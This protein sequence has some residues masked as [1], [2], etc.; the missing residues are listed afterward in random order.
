MKKSRVITMVV[1]VL[2]IIGAAVYRFNLQSGA[3]E[4][5]RIVAMMNEADASE[6]ATAWETFVEDCSRRFRDDANENLVKCYLAI[7][8]DPGVPAKEQA[9]WYA[10]A[11]AIDPGKLTET[12]RKTME[13]FGEGQ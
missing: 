5:N 1:A 9:E 3:N 13:V 12:Q 4:F 7:G 10:K 8:N 6:A 2:V 11:H